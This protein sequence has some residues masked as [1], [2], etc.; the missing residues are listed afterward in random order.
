VHRV[1]RTTRIA[2]ALVLAG[3]AT[4]LPAQETTRDSALAYLD[5]VHA[6][7]RRTHWD[8]AAVGARWAATWQRLRDTLA[9][10]PSVPNVRGAAAALLAALG[11]SHFTI[12]PGTAIAGEATGDAVP[13]MTLRVFFPYVLIT[14]VP[15]GS[16]AWD[17]GLRAGQ[18]LESV[19]GVPIAQVMAPIA[20]LAPRARDTYGPG[21]VQRALAGEVGSPVRLG[22][23][24]VDGT[25][26]ERFV[27]REPPPGELL[28]FPGLPPQHAQF[29]AWTLRHDGQ[30]IGAIRFTPWLPQLTARI[31]SAVDR[32]RGADAI[33]IDLR[34]NPGGAALMAT[35]IAGH[36]VD[37]TLLLAT[38]QA[39]TTALR[40][41]VNPR[42]VNPAM[43]PVRPFAGP[44]VLVV[45]AGSASTTELFA[46]GLQHAGRALVVGDTSAGMALPATTTPLFWGDRVLHAIADM[47]LADGR[48]LEARG[49][50]PD[51]V[52]GL[53]RRRLAMGQDPEFLV[54]VA[55]AASRA[56]QAKGLP[57]L[58]RATPGATTA[59]P[60][61]PPARSPAPADARAPASR[62]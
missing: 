59:I 9:T 57:P 7:V 13:R 16:R 21:A 1:T 24:E 43:Q 58:Q 48:S 27:E 60:V 15:P 37:D 53:D 45:D 31:D 26:R 49:V 52:V 56:R 61:T 23:R 50:V 47:R 3:V 14:D 28:Q 4:S 40:Y 5:S 46:G 2:L 20:T 17:A 51:L 35:G 44:L 62:P 11:T 36:F 25:F 6:V 33:V 10:R 42:R 8:T 39:R 54:A 18:L 55:L 22:V 41:R 30:T 29:E 12:L 19:R 32:M 38:M 34:G